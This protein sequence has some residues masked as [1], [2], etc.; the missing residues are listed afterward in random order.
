MNHQHLYALVFFAFL[1]SACAHQKQPLPKPATSTSSN[2]LEASSPS[3]I[4]STTSGTQQKSIPIVTLLEFASDFPES[5]Q[6]SQRKEL[7]QTLQKISDTPDNLYQKFKAATIYSIPGSRLRD[8]GKA[9]PLLDELS[10]IKHLNKAEY[11]LLAILREHA[12][13][14]TRLNQLIREEQKRAE[15]NQ[16]KATNLQRKLDELKQI[17][18]SMMQKSLKDSNRSNK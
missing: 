1:L 13:E 10:R 15:E 11:G 3:V 8:T 14:T 7:A 6:D 12:S 17:E 18:R 5:S 9:Q 16:Q 4:P 2:V